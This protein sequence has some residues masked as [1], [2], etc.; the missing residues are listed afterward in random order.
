MAGQVVKQDLERK[1]RGLWTLEAVELLFQAQRVQKL[2]GIH[3]YPGW[4]GIS[5]PGSQVGGLHYRY[6][7]R[8]A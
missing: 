7:R 3:Q 5:A 2:C 4:C 8:A 1:G 6:V